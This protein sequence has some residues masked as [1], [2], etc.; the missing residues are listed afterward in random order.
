[1][2]RLNH[3]ASYF[4]PIFCS[5]RPHIVILSA[6]FSISLF[7]LFYASSELL[8]HQYDDPLMFKPNS[9]DYFRT[10]LLGLFSPFLY[11]FLK[12]FLF[13]IN[14]RFLIL[15][16]IVDFPINDVF[17]LLILIGLAYP[18]VQ[19]HEGGTIKH[20]E[21]SWHIIPRQAYIFGISWALGEFTICIIGNLFNYQEIADPNINSGFTHQESANTYCNNNDMSHNDDCGCSTEYRPNV[22]E[23]S[24]ITLSKC[25]EVRNDSSSISNNVYSSEY[26]PIKPLRSSSSTYGSIRQQPHEN[27]KQLH[28]PDNSQDDTII[29]MNPIDNSLKLTTL[30]TG[31]LSFPIDEEQ[32]ILKKSFGYT[33]AVPNENTQNTTKSFTPI[34]RFIAFSTAYQLV[35]GLLLMVLVVGSNI[36]LTIGESLI[37]SMYFVYVRGHEGLFTPVVNY[38]GSRTISNFILC[39]IIPFISLNFLINT[40][41]YLRRELDDWFNNSQG[42][43]E[44]DDENTISKRVA[45]NQE[46]QH[47]LS[48]NYISMDSPDVINSSPGHFG[49]NS[50][51]LLGNTTLYYGS[52][53]GDDDDMTNDSALLRFCKK[54]V[55]NWR[56]LARNDS[57]VLGV[58]VSW[59]LLV[60]VRGILSTVYI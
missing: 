35:T 8:L 60:F 36:M 5:T 40:S 4:M 48:A 49:M 18:Q 21:C 6:L 29:M 37:L 47:P 15:N 58:M 44:D 24:D 45:T 59:S 43:F 11:Y 22:V 19:D 53:N 30:D 20:K 28:V 16:L 31:D 26:H 56:A 51:Q 52:L 1:M 13:N 33:W 46:Y 10:F 7:S 2:V 41:I 50:G 39:V 27:K 34:K 38:F 54:L 32:P 9:Q 17:M 3:A 57:F 12:T 55:K 23:R 42:E 25:I 14:Q